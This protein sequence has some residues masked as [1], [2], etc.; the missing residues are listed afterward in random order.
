MA[1]HKTAAGM[2]A[3]LSRTNEAILRATSEPE[4]FQRICD[5]AIEEG[6]FKSA[7]VLLVDSDG[8]L[9]SVAGSAEDGP[10]TFQQSKFSARDD[11]RHGRGL[12]GVAFRTGRSCISND[13]LN[14][15]SLRPWYEHARRFGIGAAAAVPIVV[16]GFPIGVLAFHLSEVGSLD[17]DVMKLMERMAENISFGLET[18]KREQGHRAAEEEEKE[19]LTRMFAALSATNEAIIRAKTRAEL[20]ER[21]CAAAVQGAKFNSTTIALVDE[22]SQ[23]LNV[24]ATA[25]PNAGEVRKSRFSV[26]ESLPEGRGM[27][28]LAYRSGMP[29]ISNDYL[30]DER[31]RPWHE[32]A[33]RDGVRSA[34]ALPLLSGGRPVGALLFRSTEKDTFTPTLLELLAR[35]AENVSFAVGNFERAEEKI[36]AEKRIEY[37][38]THDSLTGLPNR[39]SFNQLLHFA[40]EGAR[41]YER[42]FAILFIDLDRFKTINDSLGHGAGDVLLVE[43]AK[44]LRHCLRASDVVARLGGD[45]FVVILEHGERHQVERVANSLLAALS[46]PLDLCGHECYTTASIGIA[47]FPGDGSDALTL[48]KNADVA[49]YLAKED[50]KNACRFFTREMKTQTVERLRLEA[51]LRHAL[52]RNEFSLDYQPKIDLASGQI[53][54][55]EALV[56]WMHPELGTLQPA[57][58]ISIAEDT[59]LIVPL[60]RWVLR[61]ACAQGMAWQRMGLPLMPIAVNLSPRQFADE[62]LLQDIDEALQ[63]TGLPAKLLQLEVTESMVM[64]N[65]GRATKLL[66]EVRRRGIRVAIDDFGTGYSSMSL[67]KQ[68]PIDT[69]KIDRSFVRDLPSDCEDQAIAQAIIC[70]GKA[71]GMTVVAEGVETQAQESF[72][73]NH[74]C[75]EVQGYLFSRPVAADAMAELLRLGRVVAP[76]LQPAPPNAFAQSDKERPSSL[77]RPRP[78]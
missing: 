23:F 12:A 50:G 61:E 27:I 72:L 56:R 33:R 43:I 45:E 39:E 31:T 77:T 75:D 64:Q 17:D 16:G 15:E 8:W 71:L 52:E 32:S 35:L 5:I 65:V 18:F 1:L 2:F 74:A 21:V 30:A 48:T 54:G 67:M 42:K 41:R 34:A 60:G 44:R 36:E 69:I 11:S 20:Y 47:L 3:V 57:Q 78:A 40:I 59:G 38:A 28:G 55:V 73:R 53:S 29:C 76:P 46:R 26:E 9:R 66:E 70:M 4:L 49:M 62:R 24:A 22:G 51:N 68:L 10:H 13:Y 37:L 14:D 19:A 25:G 58:F 63:D 7:A 6:G